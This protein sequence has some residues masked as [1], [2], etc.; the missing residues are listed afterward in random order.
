[1]N[2]LFVCSANRDRSPTAERVF[3]DVPGWDVR[4]AGTSLD[5]ETRVSRE[6]LDWADRVFVMEER[7]LEAVTRMCPSCHGKTMVL[8]IEDVYVRNGAKLVG[9]LI[10]KMASI[11]DLDEWIRQKF[12]LGPIRSEVEV[13]EGERREFYTEE[14]P[15]GPWSR[16]LRAIR[17]KAERDKGVQ[18]RLWERLREILVVFTQSAERV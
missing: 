8:G 14:N 9:E 18:N 5:A 7:H 15:S 6:V 2:V 12:D 3:R 16:A 1:M 11:V 17:E 4:S 10:R 13:M